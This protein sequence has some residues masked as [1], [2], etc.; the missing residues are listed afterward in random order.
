MTTTPLFVL[1]STHQR[2]FEWA[3]SQ[4]IPRNRIQPI[5]YE[6][7]LQRLRGLNTITYWTHDTWTNTDLQ[8]AHETQHR[9]AWIRGTGGTV[10]VLASTDQLDPYRA[11]TTPPMNEDDFK[12][13][14]IDTATTYGWMVVHYRPA[15]TSKGYRTPLQGHKGCPDLILARDNVVILAELKTDTGNATPEQKKWLA[16]LG[17]HGRVWR[18]ADWPAVLKE[19]T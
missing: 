4:D 5:S 12:Q 2:A 14:V 3:A 17:P 13:R 18:P 10:T 8:V 1:A 19:L 7:D 9:L 6:R 16:A 15:K 11:P